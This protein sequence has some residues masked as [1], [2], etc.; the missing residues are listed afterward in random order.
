MH[1]IPNIKNFLPIAILAHEKTI[2]KTTILVYVRMQTD[3]GTGTNRMHNKLSG[4]R[5]TILS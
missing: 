3:G 5:E 4:D 1:N 2:T